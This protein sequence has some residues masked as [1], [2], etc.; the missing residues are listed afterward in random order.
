MYGEDEKYVEEQAGQLCEVFF[1]PK[2]LP[3]DWVD[4]LWELYEEG[5]HIEEAV[6]DQSCYT[7]ETFVD[8]LSD[9][10]YKKVIMVVE[11]KACGMC[12]AV[13]D[14]EKAR[15]AYINP[16][17]YM[18]R[19]PKEL[20]E[21]RLYYI[22]CFYVSPHLRHVGFLRLFAKACV[23]AVHERDYVLAGDVS[24]SRFWAADIIP[25]LAEEFGYPV[26][27]LLLGSQSYF[28]FVKLP[29]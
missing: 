4:S 28:A 12:L 7:R 20:E 14:I 24:D 25:R 22:T 10:D 9:P 11:G 26:E 23:I 6:Q 1:D 17:F 3:D 21:G 16:E 8:A 27:K 2:N 15:I 5:L 13:G 18:K 29:G 19:F